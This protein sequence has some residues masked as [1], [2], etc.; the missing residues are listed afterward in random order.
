[1]KLLSDVSTSAGVGLQPRQG[2]R[3]EAAQALTFLQPREGQ[4][5]LCPHLLKALQGHL[6]HQ[7]RVPL[8][9]EFGLP[10]LAK[11]VPAGQGEALREEGE[12]FFSAEL[13]HKCTLR[14]PPTA[15]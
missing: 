9:A 4:E 14:L 11:A 1:M 3:L 6:V 10:S 2:Q 8:D 15:F 13:A 5:H 7:L 12:T